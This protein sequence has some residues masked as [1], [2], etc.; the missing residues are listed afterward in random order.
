L[1]IGQ[2]LNLEYPTI[3]SS[4]LKLVINVMDRNLMDESRTHLFASIGSFCLSV[5]TTSN[6]KQR[7]KGIKLIDAMFRQ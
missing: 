4:A 1:N 7:E 3:D 5:E 2:I 6:K